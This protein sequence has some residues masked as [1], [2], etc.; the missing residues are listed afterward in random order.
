M[1]KKSIKI[2]SLLSLM[3]ISGVMSGCDN[4]T[5]SN[6]IPSTNSSSTVQEEDPHV[7][8]L[9]LVTPPSKTEYMEGDIF[10][11][12]GIKVKA[13]WSHGIDEDLNKNDIKYD[14][15]P[16]KEDDSKVTITYEGLTL[17][18]AIK[19][20]AVKIKSIKIEYKGETRFPL[21]SKITNNGLKVIA[22]LEDNTEKEIQTYT[23]TINSKDVTKEMTGEGLSNLAK[24]SYTVT[25][26]YKGKTGTYNFDIFNG[27]II[28][29]EDI[30]N[31]DDI[32]ATATNYLERV[33]F[34]GVQLGAMRYSNGK[35]DAKYASGQAYLGEVKKGNSFN[36]H[37]YSEVERK[38]DITMTAA[39]CVISKDI[40]SWKPVEM[41]SI[42]LN[43]MLKA[44]ANDKDI[45]ITDDVILPGGA[46][47]PNADGKY[48]YDANIWV[49][50]QSVV[51]GEMNLKK[52]D[53]IIYV[54][55]T[56]AIGFTGE[57]TKSSGT[58]NIDKFEV[59]FKD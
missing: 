49:N 58:I 25:V 4:T 6:S 7:T 56:N 16:L 14:K 10:D 59:S 31:K 26:T 1:K 38:A 35:D 12:T 11:P 15:T 23:L 42:Q 52:G 5:N 48:T 22:V 32:P 18:V 20:I 27:Y 21:G 46:T 51:F 45:V 36:V 53:N 50:W 13:Y 24:G 19:V 55:L 3:V 17:D 43:Q 2:L 41:A 8:K 33:S 9:E 28:E 47:K 57:F 39:S 34:S 40:N 29:A 37:V 44:K 30:Y 54:E